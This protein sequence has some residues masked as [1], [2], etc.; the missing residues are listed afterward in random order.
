MQY[1]STGYVQSDNGGEETPAIHP[2]RRLQDESLKANRSTFFSF[3]FL[4]VRL[5]T[6]VL[7]EMCIETM[8]KPKNSSKRR[9]PKNTK[10]E[11]LQECRK[12]ELI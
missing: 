10:A 7:P 9:N 12:E 6:A 3:P 8:R 4:R 5:D 1:N 2:S 11:L